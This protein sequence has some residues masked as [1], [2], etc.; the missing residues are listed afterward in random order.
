MVPRNFAK[1]NLHFSLKFHLNVCI[2]QLVNNL[3]AM[4]ETWV[5]SLGWEDSLEKGKAAYSSILALRI[6]WT[7]LHGVTKSWTRLSSFHFQMYMY[8]TCIYHTEWYML[9][10]KYSCLPKS[11]SCFENWIY[12]VYWGTFFF[13]LWFHIL[14]K[15]KYHY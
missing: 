10:P 11:N 1:N 5:W 9:P 4:W 14:W 12:I 6:P 3:P 15:Y 2:A 13:L 8:I 7:L